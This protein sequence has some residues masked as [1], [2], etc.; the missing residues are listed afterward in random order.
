MS[1]IESFGGG[2]HAIFSVW[3]F[4]LMQFIPFLVAYVIGSA[5]LESGDGASNARWRVFG[6]NLLLAS[7]GFITVFT[8]LGMTSTAISRMAFKHLSLSGQ[9][10]GVFIGLLALYVAGLLTLDR[11][12]AVARVGV[13]VFGFLLGAALALS[14]K[15]CVTPTLTY[16]YGLT[17]TTETVARGGA[18]LVFYTLGEFSIIAL[19]SAGLYWLILKAGGLSLR[20]GARLA[21]V[22]V[23]LTVSGMILTDKM[24]IYKSFLVGRFVNQPGHD[25]GG[26]HDHSQH[27]APAPATA[28]DHNH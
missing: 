13:K 21:C 28:H 12:S 1:I 11:K 17:Q 7:A 4:C 16:I 9:I 10:G 19:A 5:L 26:G 15:P 6:V 8:I 20:K 27:Q 2:I 24:T 18:L 22:A 3:I 25:H 23:L 14:Y